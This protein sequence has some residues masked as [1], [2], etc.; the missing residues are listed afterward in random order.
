MVE[1]AKP[2]KKPSVLNYAAKELA[3][4]SL[5]YCNDKGEESLDSIG[6]SAS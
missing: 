5:L 4:Q 1:K 6:Q 3:G 2:N